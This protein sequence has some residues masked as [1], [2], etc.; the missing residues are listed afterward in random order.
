MSGVT[1]RTFRMVTLGAKTIPIA[2]AEY[3]Q[4][5][6]W[7]RMIDSIDKKIL[8]STVEQVAKAV[9]G[10]YLGLTET[11]KARTERVIVQ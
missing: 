11:E 10:S 6:G 8:E 9:T 3:V 2:V 7:K 5:D 4:G 1:A